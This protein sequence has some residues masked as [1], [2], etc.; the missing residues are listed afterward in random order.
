MS[1]Y[2]ENDV[3]KHNW[4]IFFS[5]FPSSKNVVLCIVCKICLSKHFVHRVFFLKF[6][7]TYWLIPT[8]I[9]FLLTHWLKQQIFILWLPMARTISTKLSK[10]W[11][12]RPFSPWYHRAFISHSSSQTSHLE[13]SY[14]WGKMFFEGMTL[15][16]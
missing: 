7:V 13:E 8:N 11:I 10:N 12:C 5:F 4:T 9:L 16:S 1:S 15:S 2:I 3:A 14:V 6:I